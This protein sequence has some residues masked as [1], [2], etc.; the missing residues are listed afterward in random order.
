MRYVSLRRNFVKSM[1]RTITRIFIVTVLAL[2]ALPLLSFAKSKTLDS[3]VTNVS[4]SLVS[5]DYSFSM[6]TKKAK[7]TGNGNVM[8]QGNSFVMNGNGLEIWCDGKTRWTIDRLSEEALIEYVDDSYESFATNPALMIASVD[9]AFRE[10]S[11]SSTKFEEKVV[12]ASYLSPLHKGKGSMD[13]SSLILYF[14]SGSSVLVGAR[15]KL[16]DGSIS[17]FTITNLK[18]E[19]SDKSKESF[20]FNEKTLNASYV[21]TDLR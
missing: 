14:K 5:F 11:F 13:I 7:M 10:I 21:I 8:V 9:E 1:K 18:F 15:V 17:D 16:N 4:T 12:D 6:P 20:R 3:F 19:K 2:V